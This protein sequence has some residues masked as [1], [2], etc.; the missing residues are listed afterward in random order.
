M[1]MKTSLLILLAS[2]LVTVAATN[3]PGSFGIPG[4]DTT[5]TNAPVK[6]LPHT[7]TGIAPSNWSLLIAIGVPAL[8]A[9]LKSWAPKLPSWVL[10]IL[11][12]AVGALADYVMQLSGVPT[13]GV[14]VGALLG[15]AGVGLRELQDQLK[16]KVGP[17]APP[18]PPVAT[19]PPTA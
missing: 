14:A 16:H 5:P 17:T 4:I 13:N 10:P 3:V 6:V 8:L 12:P 18:N 9:G 1:N 15:S 7:D 2:V 11:A 19:P